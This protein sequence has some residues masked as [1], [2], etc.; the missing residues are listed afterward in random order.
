VPY[1]LCEYDRREYDLC[2][3]DLLA[4]G[5]LFYRY[6]KIFRYIRPE[7]KYFDPQKIVLKLSEVMVGSGIRTKPIQDPGSR[8]PKGTGSQIRN[9]EFEDPNP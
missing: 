5:Q 7:L 4:Y 2:E 1:D 8:G 9:T 6:R 3:Y